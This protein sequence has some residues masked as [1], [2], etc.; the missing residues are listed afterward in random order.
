MAVLVIE[1]R[2]TVVPALLLPPDT[3]EGDHLILTLDIDA[4]ARMRTAD[5]ISDLQRQLDDRNKNE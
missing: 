2:E 4:D 1:N 5:E 3:R